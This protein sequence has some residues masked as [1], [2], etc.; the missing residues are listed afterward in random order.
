[1]T[2][3]LWNQ[4]DIKRAL[5]ADCAAFSA[6]GV[7]ID[8]R[9]I[10][11]GDLFIAIKG[12]NFDGNDY[13]AD[14]LRKGACAAIISRDIGGAQK[15]LIRVDD[16]KAAL[17]TLGK[18]ARQR[19]NGKTIAVTGSVGKTS[20]KDA[21]HFLLS[22]QGKCFSTPGNLNNDIGLPLSL[23]RLPQ[24]AE[25]AI[26]ELGMNHPGE[27]EPLSRLCRPDIAIITAIAPAHMEYMKSLEA[28]A[29]EKA[30]IF[31]GIAENG[32]A[33]I[34]ADTPF[35]DRIKDF[36]KK[37]GV[38]TVIGFGEN[39]ESGARLLS[40]TLAGDYSDIQ[41]NL[42]GQDISYRLGAPGKHS[43]INSLGVLAAVHFAAS[44]AQKAK[45]DFSGWL[46]PAGRGQ[47]RD[48]PLPQGGQIRL[49]DES[50]NASPESVRAA[51][52][53]L[54]SIKPDKGG[55]RIAVLGD[56]LEMGQD[57]AAIHMALA[58]DIKQAGLGAV[59]LCGEFM[60]GLHDPALI[61]CPSFYAANSE[62]L[63]PMVAEYIQAGDAVMVK[64]SYGSKMRAIIEFLERLTPQK[65][66]HMA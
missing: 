11:P 16:A 3:A 23:A 46:P 12:P 18:Y 47:M 43:A 4:D 10:A 1:M 36:A 42:I 51:I 29:D 45:D 38:K 64:G 8:S 26:F 6:T 63:A 55:R 14:A 20:V 13:A 41:A 31:A 59:F 40:C 30:Q 62:A 15:P 21:L 25:F 32:V 58:P 53:V 28:V 5:G 19:F 49:I 44:S 34:N 61:G 37:C 35:F 33:I 65:T 2:K 17:W 9:S 52:R 57:S 60:K 56:M 7:S 50:Y 48:I 24:D 27:I 66:K 54:S 22:R 39:A